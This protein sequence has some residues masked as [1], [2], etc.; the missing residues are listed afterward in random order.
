M[1]LDLEKERKGHCFGRRRDLA[2]AHRLA[3]RYS[4]GHRQGAEHRDLAGFGFLP[5]LELDRRPASSCAVQRGAD[6][7]NEALGRIGAFAKALPEVRTKLI[8]LGRSKIGNERSCE[9]LTCD[10]VTGPVQAKCKQKKGRPV[11]HCLG[12][13]HSTWL[14]QD[15]RE[16]ALIPS[17]VSITTARTDDQSTT[18]QRS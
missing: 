11:Q 18:S 1:A 3:Q 10:F 12:L 17:M 13:V 15:D 7:C 9:S 5:N 14:Y 4:Y 16:E 8:V 6:L 2:T